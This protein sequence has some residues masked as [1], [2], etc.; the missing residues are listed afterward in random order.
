M[1]ILDYKL[2]NIITKSELLKSVAVA[3]MAGAL[4]KEIA[5]DD[6]LFIALYNKLNEKQKENMLACFLEDKFK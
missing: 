6:E 4:L 1:K 2:L 3:Y 5:V